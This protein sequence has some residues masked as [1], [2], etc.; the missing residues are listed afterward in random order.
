LK[1]DLKSNLDRASKME[2]S[3]SIKNAPYSVNKVINSRA[4]KNEIQKDKTMN[5][6]KTFLVNSTIKLASVNE[7]TLNKTILVEKSKIPQ[8]KDSTLIQSTAKPLF[9]MNHSKPQKIVI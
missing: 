3:T 5:I 6:R 2:I 4:V 1:T 9:K 7:V 8:L